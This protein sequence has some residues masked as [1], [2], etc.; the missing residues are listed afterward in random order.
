MR[1]GAA[2]ILGDR[3][4]QQDSHDCIRGTTLDPAGDHPLAIV[5]DGM[6]GHAGGDVASRTAVRAFKEHYARGDGPVRDRLRFA[7]DHANREIGAA[8]RENPHL[9]GM[10]TTLVAAA[11]SDD[12]VEWV[13][14]GDSPMF[15]Y[16][17]GRAR[18]VNEDHSFAPIIE[19]LR[20]YGSTVADYLSPHM[21]RSALM[22]QEAVE[23]VD[24]APLPERLAPGDLVV[25]CSDGLDPLVTRGIGPAIQE[26]LNEAPTEASPDERL[27]HAADALL[28]RVEALAIPR[29]DNATVLLAELQ[30]AQAG[31]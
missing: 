23:L 8:L 24:L 18:R 28:R 9:K 5:A 13:S 2:R 26:S 10:G 7:L 17:D 3:D 14:V 22:G 30:C 31:M 15:L 11:I 25:L 27:Q 29:Q 1:F 21:L 6:G 19:G 4:S 16:R 20:H 12:G